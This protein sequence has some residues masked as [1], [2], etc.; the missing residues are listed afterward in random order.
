MLCI[1]FDV[2]DVCNRIYKN[3]VGGSIWRNA[4]VGLLHYISVTVSCKYTCVVVVD[5]ICWNIFCGYNWNLSA[6]QFDNTSDK[7]KAACHFYFVDTMW[8][9]D[10]SCDSKDELL[11]IVL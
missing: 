8:N 7:K 5:W 3:P 9:C 1:A 2:R 10:F 11:T 4:A 6:D